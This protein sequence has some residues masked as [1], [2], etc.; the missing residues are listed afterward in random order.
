[1]VI[2][3]LTPAKLTPLVEKYANDYL[4]ADLTVSR[5][6]LT[7]RPKFPILELSVDS[8]TIISRGLNGID[9]AQRSELPVYA[10][11]LLNIPH[12]SGGINLATLLAGN[13]DIYDVELTHP[14]INIVYADSLHSN[15]D[16]MLPDSLATDSMTMELP[17]IN[18]NR[19]IIHGAA[20]IRYFSLADTTSVEL[21]LNSV[22]L[23]SDIQPVYNISTVATTSTRIGSI[24]PRTDINLGL[25][26]NIHWTPELPLQIRLSDFSINL[27]QLSGNF[28]MAADLAEDAPLLQEFSLNLNSAKLT[29]I[30]DILPD[31]W[32]AGL[33]TLKSDMA[34]TASVKLLKPYKLTSDRMPS[35]AISVDIPDGKL[36]YE[37]LHI[38]KG[39]ITADCEIIG[40][41]LEASYI[42]IQRLH[43]QG[44]AMDLTLKGTIREPF[45]DP[46][47][48]GQFDGYIDL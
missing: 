30:L 10:D 39:G 29:D 20:P 45:K 34:L 12:L 44:R 13:I 7:L 46:L 15:L 18:I 32:R 9:A 16:I 4:N 42:S 11:T 31:E 37:R 25:D 6:E 21:L 8:L 43:A 17:D 33:N 24:L 38:L 1:L 3:I 28:D 47:V 22:A 41:S 48:N 40:D 14:T 2:W 35:V 23:T 27:D 5:V 36:D 26:G 19:F